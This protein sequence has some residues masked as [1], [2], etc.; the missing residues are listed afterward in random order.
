MHEALI[1]M[2]PSEDFWE[3]HTTKQR[4]IKW[5]IIVFLLLLSIFIFLINLDGLMAYE[6]ACEHP[7]IVEAERKVVYIHDTY[8]DIFL[9]YTYDGVKYDDIYYTTSKN[10]GTRWDGV[11]TLTVAVAPNDPGM[12][13]RNMFDAAPVVFAFVLWSLGLAMLIYGIGVEFPSFRK[14]RVKQAN[15]PGF[16][17]RPYGKPIKYTANPDYWKDFTFI[18]VLIAFITF[19]ILTRIFP[20]TFR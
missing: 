20:Y 10:P 7:I 17:D 8:N 5:G 9:S 19:L 13:I 1:R 16:W 2:I 12:P 15:R 6:Y 18:L 3:P 11:K 4:F 14:W